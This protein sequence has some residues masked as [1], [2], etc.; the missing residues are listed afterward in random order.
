MNN[1]SAQA[2]AEQ[3]GVRLKQARLNANMTQTQLAEQ[4]GV[5]RRAV[6]NAEKGKASLDVFIALLAGL[7]LTEQLDNLLPEQPLSPIQLSKLKGKAR[8]RA[9]GERSTIQQGDPEW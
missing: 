3:L 8:Q 1:N 4:A 5:S 7:N 6:L 2:L 9:S